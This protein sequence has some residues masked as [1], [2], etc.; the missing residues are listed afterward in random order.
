MTGSHK[1]DVNN[2]S[3]APGDELVLCLAHA[4]PSTAALRD[5]IEKTA[6]QCRKAPSNDGAS[7]T[8][9]VVVT[10]SLQVK[11]PGRELPEWETSWSTGEQIM[12]QLVQRIGL[13]YFAKS[14]ACRLV[15]RL[16]DMPS[17]PAY[18]D[19]TETDVTMTSTHSPGDD[20]EDEDMADLVVREV[21]PP[22]STASSSSTTAGM[23]NKENSAEEDEEEEEG[24]SGS[25]QE[26]QDAATLTSKYLTL[27]KA[28]PLV[29]A[30]IVLPA[31]HKHGES[32]SSIKDNREG[33]ARSIFGRTWRSS[34]I[35][36]HTQLQIVTV[37]PEQGK[38][39]S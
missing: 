37:A 3:I 15:A 32:T 35:F 39:D 20:D 19:A 18:E 5:L 12:A 8:R 13:Q 16:I 28:A 4:A 21:P 34:D 10:G 2:N 25:A 33:V 7:V 36:Q 22:V 30:T 1:D 24:R 14:A 29:K 6:S 27:K 26:F 38:M 17:P 11:R 31:A 23:S 9:H